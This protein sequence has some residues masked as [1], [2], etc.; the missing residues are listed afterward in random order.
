MLLFP[1]PISMASAVGLRPAARARSAQAQACGGVAARG[2]VARDV[3]RQ[4]TNSGL[5]RRRHDDQVLPGAA[6]LQLGRAAAA[7]PAA[8]QLLQVSALPGR[9]GWGGVGGL[10]GTPPGSTR[11]GPGGGARLGLG[12]HRGERKPPPHLGLTHKQAGQGFPPRPESLDY[13]SHVAWRNG[14]CSPAQLGRGLSGEV[15]WRGPG[16]PPLRG[17]K[18]HPL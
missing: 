9:R 8:A 17:G 14:L 7:G 11:L 5:R 1:F 10:L 18:R 12:G 4:Q 3:S 2:G 13:N 16:N 15:A 6:M